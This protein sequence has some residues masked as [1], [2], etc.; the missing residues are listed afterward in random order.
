MWK[1]YTALEKNRK[2]FDF[3]VVWKAEFHLQFLLNIYDMFFVKL[4]SV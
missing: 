4:F 2:C 1:K 3:D